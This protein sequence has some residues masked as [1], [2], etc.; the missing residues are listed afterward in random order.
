MHCR[1]AGGCA[2]YDKRPS[3]C[4]GYLC[5][6]VMGIPVTYPGTSGI[7]WTFQPDGMFAGMTLAMGH[8]LDASA[9]LDDVDVRRDINLLL[10]A[11]LP[12]RLSAVVLRSANHIV[13]F[14]AAGE[15]PH[16]VADIDPADPMRDSP[17]ESTQ[18]RAHLPRIPMR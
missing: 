10:S 6:W 5:L 3:I 12:M 9:A 4:R 14:D 11:H 2:I 18:R 13:R 1:V 8:C 7:A 15:F 16:L 17:R